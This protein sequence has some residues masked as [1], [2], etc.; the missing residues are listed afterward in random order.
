MTIRG[1]IRIGPDIMTG[2]SMLGDGMIRG[3]I[4]VG[5][6]V[7]G[8]IPDGFMTRGIMAGTI[9]G[10]TDGTALGGEAQYLLVAPVVIPVR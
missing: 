9:R 5:I 3:F 4:Q 7:R 6:T 2:V 10:I 8:I 1:T